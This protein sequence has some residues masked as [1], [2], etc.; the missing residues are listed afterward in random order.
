MNMDD[1][2]KECMQDKATVKK[3]IN[4]SQIMKRPLDEYEMRDLFTVIARSTTHI[5]LKTLEVKECPM[6]ADSSEIISNIS[7]KYQYVP[8]SDQMYIDCLMSRLDENDVV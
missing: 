5:D 7:V 4:N 3:I 1:Y 6:F 8:V 2:T